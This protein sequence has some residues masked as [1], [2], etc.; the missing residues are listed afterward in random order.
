[1]E[2]KDLKR[3]ETASPI[4]SVAIELGIKVR[5]SVATCFREQNHAGD[6]NTPTL[7]FNPG[8]NTFFCKTCPDVGGSV[9]D[10]VCQYR[11]WGKEE[12]IAWLAHRAE[13]DQMTSALY[14]GKGKKK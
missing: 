4:I 3:L 11:G 10:L 9:V 2:A 13:F 7:V 6:A 14:H 8:K 12:A 5:G 1:M